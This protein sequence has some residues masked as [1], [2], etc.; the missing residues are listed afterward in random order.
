MNAKPLPPAEDDAAQTL[1]DARVREILALLASVPLTERCKLAEKVCKELEAES[2]L[3]R[4]F[5]LVDEDI[6]G[7]DDPSDAQ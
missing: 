3:R 4:S 6:E 7:V 2:Y 5:G 1:H